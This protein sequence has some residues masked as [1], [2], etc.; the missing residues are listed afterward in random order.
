VTSRHRDGECAL[1]I[2]GREECW[3][4]LGSVV[5]LIN[6]YKLPTTPSSLGLHIRCPHTHRCHSVL[7][8]IAMKRCGLSKHHSIRLMMNHI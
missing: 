6:V 4:C 5:C 2:N 7:I 8:T 3:T 1:R